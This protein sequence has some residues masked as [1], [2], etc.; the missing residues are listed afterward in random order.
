MS[1]T[2]LFSQQTKAKVYQMPQCLDKLDFK[3]IRVLIES[4]DMIDRNNFDTASLKAVKDISKE[5]QDKKLEHA[6]MV[7]KRLKEMKRSNP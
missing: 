5:F 4:M 2:N 1:K 3:K 6:I 7:L